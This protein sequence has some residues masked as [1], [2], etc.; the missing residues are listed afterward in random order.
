MDS[1]SLKLYEFIAEYPL[2]GEWEISYTDGTHLPEDKYVELGYITIDESEEVAQRYPNPI[3]P[4]V[5]R[6]VT[7]QQ[8]EC[9]FSKLC[10]GKEQANRAKKIIRDQL[11]DSMIRTGLLRPQFCLMEEQTFEMKFQKVMKKL[12]EHGY[13]ILIADT[14]AL[15]RGAIS[16]LHKTLSNVLIWTVVPVFVMSEVSSK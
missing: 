6:P 12:S 16:F 3:L 9:C 2:W 15:R 1:R 7:D 13:L 8:I 10:Q 11:A 4:F 5:F 14:S